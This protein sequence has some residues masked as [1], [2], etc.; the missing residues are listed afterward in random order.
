MLQGLPDQLAQYYQ[1]HLS[2]VS[3]E[4]VSAAS[5]QIGFGAVN[6]GTPVADSVPA[7]P[8]AEPVEETIIT[9]TTLSIE[10]AE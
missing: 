3:P 1:S 8:A 4:D 7:S 5:R 10:E 2:R 9:D 6:F